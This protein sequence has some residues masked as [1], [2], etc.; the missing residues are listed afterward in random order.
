MSRR[1]GILV[2]SRMSSSRLPGKALRD[3]GGMPLLAWVIRRARTLPHPVFLATSEDPSD[4]PLVALAEGEGVKTHRGPLD[5]VLGRAA[6]AARRFELDVIARLCGDRPYFDTEEMD[7]AI[8]LALDDPTIDLVSNW[9][10]GRTAPGLT[11]EVIAWTALERAA[12]E[13]SSPE[14]REHL[15]RIAEVLGIAHAVER[16]RP[17]GR[18]ALAG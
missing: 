18:P 11:T 6:G 10:P 12:R 13:A 5:D 16:L 4:D 14:D 3:F 2:F 17:I 8:G 9:I 1:A 15:T 7:R